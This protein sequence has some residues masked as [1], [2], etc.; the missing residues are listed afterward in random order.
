MITFFGLNDRDHIQEFQH[1]LLE[2]NVGP[3]SVHDK[4][5]STESIG[6]NLS[7]F[8][9][10]EDG[11][12]LLVILDVDDGSGGTPADC[13]IVWP[14]YNNILHRYRPHDVMVL[15]SQV[16]PV[17]EYNQFYPFKEDVLPIGVFSNKIK[18]VFSMREKFAPVTKDIDVFF[19][20]GLK[21]SKNRPYAWPKNR[22]IKR[23]WSGASVRGYDK[24][25]E[26]RENRRDIK[27]E[28]FDE[29]VSPD[30]FYNLVRRSKICID[31]PGVGLSSR[32]FYEFMVFGKCVLSL[33]QQ[34]TPWECQ[35]NVHYRSM[36]EDLDFETLESEIDNL[37]RSDE[38]RIAIEENVRSIETQLTLEHMITRA[39]R[40][41]RE[42][43]KNATQRLTY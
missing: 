7:A 40:S 5:L 36:G 20:G 12:R 30:D 25:L 21:H 9:W 28:L 19:A 35:E 41:I 43:A 3:D 8:V 27:F 38:S 39:E 23:W 1:R 24:L 13:K 42:K 26:I 22:D 6:R 17:D 4:S 11:K 29:S 16:H 33:R 10:Q 31:L 34:L 32:K 37:L 18:D 15:K 14:S 2:R